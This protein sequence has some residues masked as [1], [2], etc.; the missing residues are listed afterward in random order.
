MLSREIRTKFLKYFKK[1][2]HVIVPSSSTVPHEDPTLLFT[3]AGM[4]QFKDFFLGKTKRD[5]KR[6]VSSQKCIRVGGKHNDLDNVGHTERHITFFEMLGN[7][8]FGDYFKKE[9]IALAWDVATTVF[10]FPEEKLF[11]S[12]YDKD[13]ESFELWKTIISEKKISRIGEKENFW[14]MGDTGPCGPCSELF[15]DRGDTFGQ[16]TSI[17]EDTQGSRFFEFWNL[18]FMEFNREKGQKDQPL[19]K[20]SVDTGAGLERI[21]ALLMNAPNI[22]QTDILRLLIAEI[23]N[24]SNITYDPNDQQKAPAFHVIADHIRTLAFAIAD[25]ATPSNIKRGYVL[26]KIL[27]RALRYGKSLNLNAP[28]LSKLL[29]CLIETMGEDYHTL[30]SSSDRIGEILTIEEE[31]FFQTLQRGGNILNKTIALAQQTVKK[32]ISGEQAFK[33]K[34]TYGFPLEEILLIAKDLSLTV[35]LEQYQILEEKAK[36]LSRQTQSMKEQKVEVNFYEDFIRHHGLSTFVG[37]DQNSIE[38]TIK[39]LIVNHHFVETIEEGQKGIVI[40]DQTPFYAEKGGQVGDQG[41][42][43]HGNNTFL[44]H[45]CQAPFHGIIAHIGTLQKGTLIVGE[46]I[47]ATIDEKRRF[48]IAK[49]HSATHLLHYSLEKILGPHIRQAGSL[50]EPNRLRFDFNHHKPP[51]FEE[52]RAIEILI[53][54][55]IWEDGYV[56]TSEISLEEAHKHPE[57]KQFFGEKYTQ[58]VRVVSFENYS[59]EL[60]GGIHVKHLS[61]L[62]IFRIA[63]EG[64]IAKGIRRIEAVIGPYAE[65]LHYKQEDHLLSISRLLK[66]NIPML[67]E[68]I[69]SLLKENSQLKEQMLFLRHQMLIELATSLLHQVKPINHIPM[70]HAIVKVSKKELIQLANILIERMKTGIVVLCLKTGDTCQLLVKVS[71]DLVK[72][73]LHADDFIQ[74][75]LAIIEGSGGGKKDVARAGGK[76]SKA[77]IIAFDKI[78]EILKEKNPPLHKRKKK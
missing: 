56:T 18:V 74:N 72:K 63:K 17:L 13:E 58:K 59:K 41:V 50:V 32:E 70:L 5:Y 34:D 8:S 31:S 77:V 61:S 54:K 69:Q 25:G 3:N 60:C 67:E 21:V 76:N 53:N 73:G 16:A 35:N 40:L 26:R 57:I 52:L 7:F 46:P 23:E 15:F 62:T 75:V 65:A 66:A 42:L 27:R 20:K 43:S 11:V 1:K 39:G 51:T 37:Y 71:N 47:L 64:S 68:T 38:A 48:D 4:N 55:K 36:E 9:A 14:A 45:D 29:P 22:F 30:K 44:V 12:V 49:H 2:G 28:F 19:S 33:L 24:I 78:K 6:A 10:G